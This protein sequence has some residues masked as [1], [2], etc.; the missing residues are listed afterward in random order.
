[1]RILRT[2]Q[3]SHGHKAGG[4]PVL[5]PQRGP[6]ILQRQRL[7]KPLPANN[8]RPGSAPGQTK[9]TYLM[10]PVERLQF[11]H[12]LTGADFHPKPRHWLTPLLIAL[13]VVA[14]M[15]LL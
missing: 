14:G 10:S 6:F 8:P 9:E 7:R 2:V 1:V 13:C 3:A 15:C 11:K 12:R 5:E 4:N